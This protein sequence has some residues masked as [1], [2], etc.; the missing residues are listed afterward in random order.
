[1]L[2]TTYTE[3]RSSVHTNS[4]K[5]AT[6][7]SDSKKTI[8]LQMHDSDT[9]K[10]SFDISK[11]WSYAVD[12]PEIYRISTILIWSKLKSE[13]KFNISGNIEWSKKTDNIL[14]I[15]EESCVVIVLRIT[16]VKVV[17]RLNVTNKF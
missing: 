6:F 15:P 16:H 1:M 14:E 12:I 10:H 17:R 11:T 4:E 2:K 13:Q 5:I 3:E 9:T 7:N 8:K